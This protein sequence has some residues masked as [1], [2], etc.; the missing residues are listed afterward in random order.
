MGSS[1][2][3]PALI[4]FLAGYSRNGRP[5]SVDDLYRFIIS[6]SISVAAD[7]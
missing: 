2:P 4:P 1:A 7:L 3:W 5:I 6:R